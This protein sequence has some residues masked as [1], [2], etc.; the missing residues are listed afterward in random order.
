MAASPA[1]MHDI[2]CVGDVHEG[3]A[4]G[5]RVDPETGVSER[6]LDLHRNFARAAQFAIE[7]K[8]KLFCVLG[9]LFDRP[10][11]A[12]V[13]REMVRRDVIEPLGK[14]G[15]EVLLLGGNHDLPRADA[16]AT[17]LD[18]FRGYPHVTVI[19]KPEALVRE[20]GGKR[21]GLIA[22]PYV[23][24]EQILDLVRE[25]RGEDFPREQMGA[26]AREILKGWI[27]NRARELETDF[28]V[29]LGHFWVTRAQV[30]SQ[31]HVEIVPHDFEF[32]LGML[33]P[34]VDLAVFGH[35]HFHQAIDDR[36]VY[37]GAPERIDWG[38]RGDPK[39]FLT[40]DV[41]R[42]TWSFSE[43]PAREMLLIEVDVTREADPTAAILAALP[44]SVKDALVR[45]RITANEG[46]RLSVD[47]ARLTA[48]LDEAFHREIFWNPP[49]R[50][51][52]RG[53]EEFFLDP[54]GLFESFVAANLREHPHRDAIAKEGTAILKEVLG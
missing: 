14:A 40:L 38:E 21:V 49:E 28:L 9:D 31:T 42:K 25:H 54:L 17:S 4:F 24:P 12:P 35:V 1:R 3:I 18:D 32:D 41:E 46:Q 26:V 44:A 27:A 23:H 39:G 48:R 10:H 30:H 16:K 36:V 8:A 47:E 29:L 5:Y 2:V 22:L 52:I 6:A 53:G 13:F 15:I 45:L 51:V 43:L 20:I 50:E 33:P 7:Q 34:A 37:T 19:K 11:V